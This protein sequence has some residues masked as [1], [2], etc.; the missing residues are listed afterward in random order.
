MQN[1]ETTFLVNYTK[2]FVFSDWHD[3]NFI[4]FSPARGP[5]GSWLWTTGGPRPQVENRW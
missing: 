3:K 4:N 2:N 1:F 5:P